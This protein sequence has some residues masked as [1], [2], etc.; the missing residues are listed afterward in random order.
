[1]FSQY[2]RITQIVACKG[3]KLRGQVSL[4]FKIIYAAYS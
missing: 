1:M 3:V 2:G 4:Y